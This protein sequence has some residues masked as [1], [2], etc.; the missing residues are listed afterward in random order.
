MCVCVCVCKVYTHAH[1]YTHTHTHTHTHS[2]DGSSLLG[3]S[4]TDVRHVHRYGK[5]K[6]LSLKKKILSLTRAT[7]SAMAKTL[8]SQCSPSIFAIYTESLNFFKLLEVSAFLA[9]LQ[10]KVTQLSRIF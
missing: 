5:K 1:T 4:L 9:Y 7:S 10:N 2:K 6:S 8:K 3:L